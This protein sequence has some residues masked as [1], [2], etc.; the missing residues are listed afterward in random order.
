MV[1]IERNIKLDDDYSPETVLIEGEW[2]KVDQPTLSQMMS[3]SL[4]GSSTPSESSTKPVAPPTPDPLEGLDDDLKKDK[5]NAPRN[6]Q[7]MFNE[8]KQV[9]VR[10]PD[11]Q[12]NWSCLRH[13][14]C[15]NH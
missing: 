10:Q 7:H 5:A 1:S 3:T 9:K 15:I 6:L 11:Y 13:S 4:S 12:T 2:I 14:K 8:Y